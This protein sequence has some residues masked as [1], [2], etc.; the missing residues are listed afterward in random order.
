MSS[1]QAHYKFHWL[2]WGVGLY[3]VIF[4]VVFLTYGRKKYLTS[5]IYLGIQEGRKKSDLSSH[6][7]K[8]NIHLEGNEL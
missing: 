5:M 4:C 2:W 8:Q 1:F 7:E 6:L 3:N